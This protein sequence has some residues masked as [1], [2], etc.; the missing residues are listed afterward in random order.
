MAT[1]VRDELW[2]HR[3]ELAAE[4]E[5]QEERREQIVAVMAERDL[6]RAK[7]AGDAIEHAAPEPRAQRAHRGAV[8][9]DALHDAIGVLRLDPERHPARR[10]VAW[11]HVGREARLLLVEV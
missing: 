11:Q 1:V 6:R 2:G 3:L 9:D 7:L 10:E 4:E 8:G 5:V